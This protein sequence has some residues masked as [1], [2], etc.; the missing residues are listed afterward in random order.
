MN[1]EQTIDMNKSLGVAMDQPELVAQKLFDVLNKAG[2]KNRYLGW[3][4]KFFVRLNGL[5]PGVVDKAL[6]KQ[7]PTIRRFAQSK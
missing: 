7:L 5:F 2:A 4:E 1:T 6:L 3:P